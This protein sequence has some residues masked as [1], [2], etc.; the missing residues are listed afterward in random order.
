M[1]IYIIYIYIYTTRLIKKDE[2][3][4]ECTL[5]KCKSS[6]KQSIKNP[7]KEGDFCKNR[8]GFSVINY[9]CKKASSQESDQVPN[10]CFNIVVRTFPMHKLKQEKAKT[11]KN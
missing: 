1:Y 10:K 3:Y 7:A 5:K 11:V 2:K 4:K 8:L 9:F 6:V